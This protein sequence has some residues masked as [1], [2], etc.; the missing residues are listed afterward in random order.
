MGLRHTQLPLQPRRSA[1]LVPLVP[2]V[3]GL[4]KWS[5]ERSLEAKKSQDDPNDP[6]NALVKVETH[7][8]LPTVA[9][10]LGPPFTIAKLVHITP[11]SL[12]FMVPITIVFM[13]FINHRSITGGPHIVDLWE[14]TGAPHLSARMALQNIM[15]AAQL[16]AEYSQG[17]DIR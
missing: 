3:A 2:S 14:S 9:H 1:L 16:S 4:Y 17:N 6:R 13:G 10:L 12:W 8:I 5:C 7:A 11:I 15:T